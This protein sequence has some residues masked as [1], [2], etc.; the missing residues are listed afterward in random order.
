MIKINN[1]LIVQLS[2]VEWL[3]INTADIKAEPRFLPSRRKAIELV[4]NEIT[5]TLMKPERN[6]IPDLIHDPKSPW[7]EFENN[8]EEGWS[9][10]PNIRCL[11]NRQHHLEVA[12]LAAW[13]LSKKYDSY[14]ELLQSVDCDT[15]AQEA[16]DA[17]AKKLYPNEKLWDG[18][19]EDDPEFWKEH[20]IEYYEKYIKNRTY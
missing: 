8:F 13:E 16:Y 5:R 4:N 2:V 9:G 14:D 15:I 11:A 17:A 20:N 18:T 19:H 7:Y 3:A 6:Q 10:D 12:N 1:H